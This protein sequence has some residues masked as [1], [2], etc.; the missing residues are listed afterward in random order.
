MKRTIEE[1]RK[2]TVR[3]KFRKINYYRI[4]RDTGEEIGEAQGEMSLRLFKSW[5]KMMKS[6]GRLL[7]GML[8]FVD[9]GETWIWQ[10]EN[11]YKNPK[12]FNRGGWQKALDG[13]RED[14]NP[15]RDGLNVHKTYAERL[16][17]GN[18]I[19]ER[20]RS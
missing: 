17:I 16:G 6:T 20:M 8:Q 15:E 3:F 13:N 5:F 7:C 2:I 18:A 11:G 14:Y 19:A 9:S 10:P 12:W 1:E 4:K